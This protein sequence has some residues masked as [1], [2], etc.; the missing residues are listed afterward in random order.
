V[1]R[2]TASSPSALWAGSF[3]GERLHAM[4]AAVPT[5]QRQLVDWVG[6]VARVLEQR[7]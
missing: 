1:C 3:A 7:T 4:L 6:E 2:R 5:S